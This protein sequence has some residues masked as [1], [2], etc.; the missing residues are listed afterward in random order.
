MSAML[1][2]L[3]ILWLVGAVLTLAPNPP[4]PNA[5]KLGTACIL[6]VIL[7]LIILR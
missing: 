4:F 3:I 5:G 7:L 6:V 2:V 1:I